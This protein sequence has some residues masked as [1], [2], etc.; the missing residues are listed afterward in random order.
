MNK[1]KSRNFKTLYLPHLVN[2]VCEQPQ[3]II[4][5]I[6]ILMQ[7]ELAPNGVKMFL[8]S[9]LNFQKIIVLLSRNMHKKGSQDLVSKLEE[10]VAIHKKASNDK[11][12]RWFVLKELKITKNTFRN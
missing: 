1:D 9:H 4:D 2:L 7:N 10:N 5:R 11:F 6:G 3:Y 12:F 8:D